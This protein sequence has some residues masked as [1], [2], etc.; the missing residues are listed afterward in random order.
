MSFYISVD[1]PVK[2]LL[3]DFFFILID[4]R[5]VVQVAAASM[6]E[7]VVGGQNPHSYIH[8]HVYH[9]IKSEPNESNESSNLKPEHDERK[10]VY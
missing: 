6:V 5:S 3:H 2:N 10:G 8:H 9:P 1:I 4:P 7:A